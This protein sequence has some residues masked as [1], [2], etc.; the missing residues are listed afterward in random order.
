VNSCVTIQIAP[1]CSLNPRAAAWFFGGICLVSF[2]IAGVMAIEGLW[3]ILPFAGLEM[4]VLG[5]A[6]ASSMQ[7]RHHSQTITVSDEHITIETCWR[8][9]HEQVVFPRHWARVKLKAADTPLH[10]SRLTI[11]SHGRSYEVGSFLNEEERRAVAARL[12]RS[13]GRMNESPPLD[14]RNRSV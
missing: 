8:A 10:P 14:A 7:R 1:N 2:S 11:E 5:W 9:H 13:I 6:L 3:P 12:R 4:L